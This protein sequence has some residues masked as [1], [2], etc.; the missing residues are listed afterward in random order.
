MGLLQR[1]IQYRRMAALPIQTG[2]LNSPHFAQNGAGD[3]IQNAH[4]HITKLA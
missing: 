2:R 3:C 1:G 4:E